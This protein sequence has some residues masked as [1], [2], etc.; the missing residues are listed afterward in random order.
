MCYR[1][2]VTYFQNVDSVDTGGNNW[3]IVKEIKSIQIWNNGVKL[4]L[5]TKHIIFWIEKNTKDTPKMY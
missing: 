3:R 4:F 5:F 1:L 2:Y